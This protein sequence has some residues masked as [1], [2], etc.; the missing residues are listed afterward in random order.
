[1]VRSSLGFQEGLPVECWLS[2]AQSPGML[3]H[4]TFVP[5]RVQMKSKAQ[6]F[7]QTQNFCAIPETIQVLGLDSVFL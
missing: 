6:M 3:A 1:M 2:L 5:A 7:G 4:L